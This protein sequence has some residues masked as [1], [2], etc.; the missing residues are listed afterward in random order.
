M[1]PKLLPRPFLALC[2][3]S[4]VPPGCTAVPMKPESEG[5]V[6]QSR[7]ETVHKAAVDALV[8]L[9]FDITKSEPLYLEGYRPRNWGFFSSSGGET[10]GIWLTSLDVTRTSVFINTA[11]TSF[12]RMGQKTWDAEILSQLNKTLGQH[13]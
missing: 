13:E 6:F 5:S 4:I 12:G 2:L 7:A 9:G 3:L 1:E 11:T 8:V 10:C